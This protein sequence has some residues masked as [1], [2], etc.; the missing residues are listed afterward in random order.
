MFMKQII[1]RTM[2]IVLGDDGIIHRKVFDDVEIDVC[3]CIENLKAIMELSGG[4]P[5]IMLT[6]GRNINAHT[7][8]EA[9]TFVAGAEASKNRIAEA[10]VVNSMATRLTAN[11]YLQVN[12]PISPTRLFKSDIEA[13]EWLH[14]FSL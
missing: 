4:K 12:K 13:L 1:T 10:L 14:T 3:D 9:R 11:F 2:E 6:D 7:T 8:P 5:Y